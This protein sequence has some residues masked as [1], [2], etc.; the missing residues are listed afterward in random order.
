M[1]CAGDQYSYEQRTV[2]LTMECV[3][4][5]IA[6]GG[7]RTQEPSGDRQGLLTGLSFAARTFQMG[8]DY[9]VRPSSSDPR[10][11]SVR[12]ERLCGWRRHTYGRSAE[13]WDC[14]P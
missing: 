14:R 10:P 5:T 1:T 11:E 4:S 9:G 2:F 3:E 13:P 12:Q 6:R 7:E 8:L